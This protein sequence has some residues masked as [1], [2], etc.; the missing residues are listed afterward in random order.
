M[1]D[2]STAYTGLAA[3]LKT[4]IQ[5]T[6]GLY[7]FWYA[8]L[9]LRALGGTGPVVFP[10]RSEGKAGESM[11]RFAK[12]YPSIR[13]GQGEVLSAAE[14]ESIILRFGYS[15]DVNV[16]QTGRDGFIAK[17]LGRNHP[18]MIAFMDC[19]NP[20][21]PGTTLTGRPGIDYGPHWSLII[22]DDGREYRYIDPNSPDALKTET[23][24]QFLASNAFVDSYQY[25]QF[26]AKI[27]KT[28]TDPQGISPIGTT[29]PTGPGTVYDLGPTGRQNL[30]NVLISVFH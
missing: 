15:C 24:S 21:Q 14:M 25:V 6:C 12:A 27:P 22:A 17:A 28:S 18:V 7:S 10:R 3:S 9:L 1:A 23:H 20:G 13:S 8:T 29:K 26:W 4:Q 19:G 16:A 30:K 11:R 2:L 5:G